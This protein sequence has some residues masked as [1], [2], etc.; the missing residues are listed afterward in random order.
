MV[1]SAVVFL[2]RTVHTVHWQNRKG[3]HMPR[4]TD[5]F[6]P[7]TPK[8]RQHR[9]SGQA[10]VTLNGHDN[11]L[12]PYGTKA[13][14]IEYDRLIA[15]WLAG[16]RHLPSP[17]TTDLTVVELC[18]AFFRYVKTYYVK[19]GQP[20]GTLTSIK[21]AIDPL[22]QL[23]G[24][25]PVADFG[26]K[27]LKAL[28]HALLQGGRL[29]RATINKRIG[30]IK[31]M[32]QWGVAEELVPPN[33]YHALSALKGLRKGRTTARESAPVTPVA[34]TVVEATLLY[35]PQVVAD[36][37]RIQRLS[38]CP[39]WR[40]VPVASNGRGPFQAR[41]AVPTTATTRPSTTITTG[42]SSSGRK[43]RKCCAPTLLRPAMPTVFRRQ[44][45]SNGWKPRRCGPQDAAVLR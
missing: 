22:Q 42:S 40:S 6:L 3:L 8:Y 36:M 43:P 37:V 9:A 31:Q 15:E 30:I 45:P 5:R 35:L 25:T 27:R 18:A 39:S 34:T 44:N 16:G 26:P 23:Y 14:R 24:R 12:G 1:G 38:G 29:N 17:G 10:V 13:S 28:R 32:F 20:T 19:D 33:F 2:A 21:L 7:P 41:L 4:F 11:Y